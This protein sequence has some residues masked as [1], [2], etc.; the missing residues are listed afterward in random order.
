MELTIVKKGP[1]LIYGMCEGRCLARAITKGGTT[2]FIGSK[3]GVEALKAA[4]GGAEETVAPAASEPPPPAPSEPP[5][6]DEE[7]ELH[8]TQTMNASDAIDYVQRIDNVPELEEAQEAEENGKERKT[9]LKAI[10]AQF[11]F[12]EGE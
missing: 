1:A 7:P 12:L 4:L 11:D 8:A 2:R 5:P 10:E 9:V 3:E 6:V